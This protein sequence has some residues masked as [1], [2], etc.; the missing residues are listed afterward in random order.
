M[1]MTNK[2][3]LAAMLISAAALWAQDPNQDP[4]QPL[5]DPP[6]RV[7]RL[8]L[9]QGQVSFQPATVQDWTA[10]TSITPPPPATISTP[11]RTRARSCTWAPRPYD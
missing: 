4:N 6:S 2:I 8:N 11:M 10:A 1:T 9:I 7:A 3:R 5:Q